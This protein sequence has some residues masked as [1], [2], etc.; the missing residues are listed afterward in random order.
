MGDSTEIDFSQFSSKHYNEVAND[1][2]TSE[3]DFSQFSSQHY[4]E[5]E[6]SSIF[7]WFGNVISGAGERAANLAGS[8]L[9]TIDVVGEDL[10]RKVSLGGFAFEGDDIL[11]TYKTGSEYAELLASSDKPTTLKAGA[12]ALKTIDLGYEESTN[13]ESVKKEFSEGGAFSGSAYAETIAYGFET[14]VKSIPDMVAT[15]YAL[16]VYIFARSG[17]IGEKRATNK[18]KKETELVDV[19]EAA[20]FAV[21]S[22][23]LERI[24]AKGMTSKLKEDLG[25]K[26]LESGIKN[27]TAR[28]AKAGGV[29]LTKE[30]TTEALQE[31]LVEYVG[32]RYGTDVALDFNEALDRAAGAAVAGGIF[33]GAIG[34]GTASIE[35]ITH[36]SSETTLEEELQKQVDDLKV[37]SK[38]K[39]TT[40]ESLK[41]NTT[42]EIINDIE[43]SAININTATTV[44]EAVDI[45]A[46]II[47]QELELTAEF[48]A[49]LKSSEPVLDQTVVIDESIPT[50]DQSVAI[51]STED[52]AQLSD[53]RIRIEMNS[54]IDNAAKNIKTATREEIPQIIPDQS[55]YTE[56]S[57]ARLNE[58]VAEENKRRTAG[59]VDQALTKTEIKTEPAKLEIKPEPLIESKQK[60]A[61]D[62]KLPKIIENMPERIK[63]GL[64]SFKPKPI[65]G[66]LY[67][68]T[69]LEGVSNL[70]RDSLSNNRER[71]SVS[72]LFVTDDSSIALGQGENKGVSIVFD[73][74]LVSG[75]EHKKPGT[76]IGGV[77][78]KEYS[79]DYINKN[80][81]K[82]FTV[83]KGLKLR[84]VSKVFANRQFAK[85]VNEDG[86][87]TY[88]R[89]DLAGQ[90]ETNLN[91]KVEP[92]E[93]AT[94]EYS[95]IQLEKYAGKDLNINIPKRHQGLFKERGI[96]SS[97][98][99]V[100]NIRNNYDEVRQGKDDSLILVKTEDKNNVSYITVK[101]NDKGAFEVI[102]SAF[103]HNSIVANSP[104]VW[105]KGKEGETFLSQSRLA[106]KQT[107][108]TKESV[109]AAIS[110]QIT[111]LNKKLGININI[112]SSAEVGKFTNAKIPE[113]KMVK[114][115][116]KGNSKDVYLV[117]DHLSDGKD[118][119]VTLAH[120][121]IG[122]VGTDGI[123][124]KK[125]G[126]VV[127]MYGDLKGIG[128]SRFKSIES[129][130]NRR[131]GKMNELRQVREFIAIAAERNEKSGAIGKFI[132]KVKA[133]FNEGL[134]AL[135]FK[136][137]VGMSD[138]DSIL[139]RSQQYVEGKGA[140]KGTPLN[141][142]ILTREI[143]GKDG[144]IKTAK[145]KADVV[146]RRTQKKRDSA[147][148]LLRCV[149]A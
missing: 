89:K 68:E 47:N 128:G 102:D 56:K 44:D 144:K 59:G 57:F 133:Y 2:A 132:S 94:D 37:S 20:P 45:S 30:A 71:G 73:G 109:Q 138:I 76:G 130:V 86:S 14:G 115:F 112:I 95:N 38:P 31:G 121:L 143:K 61:V 42:Q 15:I 135:G 149:N 74:D 27:M 50:L 33:G 140:F 5:P 58:L 17:E 113:G 114:A 106:T 32:E 129:E 3:I 28:I 117:Y 82:E 148:R 8:L 141:E 116:V 70:L 49:Q 9:S 146:L 104:V 40:E 54:L 96:S 147:L 43:T 64:G 24:G 111:N 36:K 4:V 136:D 81:I 103:V 23:L 35:A 119:S 75:A 137:T 63:V 39:E 48:D 67:R 16:P 93:L 88:T 25:K 79:T 145:A 100:S 139:M 65:G 142:I 134:R 7:G 118:A 26:M 127:S 83:K 126:D 66:S 120:E 51:E 91:Q 99:F 19:L 52:I 13:W 29:A 72:K 34:S 124:G 10:E 77:T 22:S 6:E 90:K 69:N 46:N 62:P 21:A 60:V 122:H 78:G 101:K 87:V 97:E 110:N 80:A 98:D 105:S 84:G 123:I 1:N 11:P 53:E 85:T 12:K 55:H 18:G 125:W 131:Y 108:N 41:P 92:I 107:N